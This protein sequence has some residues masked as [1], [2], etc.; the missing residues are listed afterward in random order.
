MNCKSAY[1][2]ETVDGFRRDLRGHPEELHVHALRS[3]PERRVGDHD[4]RLE[5]LAHPGREVEDVGVDEIYAEV[6]LVRVEL[7][8]VLPG[9][10]EGVPV[11]VDP[12]D[13]TPEYGRAHP[14]RL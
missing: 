9:D 10:L 2:V 8:A 14:E 5:P 7:D 4:V 11:D 6:V 13:V 12:D 1:L 3:R